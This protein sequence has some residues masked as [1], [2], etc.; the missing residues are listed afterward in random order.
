MAYTF[1][2]SSVAEP[3]Y[4]PYNPDFFSRVW[5]AK[6]TGKPAEQLVGFASSSQL[7]VSESV[8]YYSK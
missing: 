2:S 3:F 6:Q 5:R 4:N 8:Y 7:T 1:P